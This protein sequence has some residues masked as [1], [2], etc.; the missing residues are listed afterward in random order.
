MGDLPKKRMMRAQRHTRKEVGLEKHYL[1][2]SKGSKSHSKG[3]RV[4]KRT[5]Q[6]VRAQSRTRKEVGLENALPK[7]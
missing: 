3:G 6:E 5:I 7:R 4:R 1:K 2:G